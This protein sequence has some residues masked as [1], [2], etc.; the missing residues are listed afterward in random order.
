M[1][2]ER[3]IAIWYTGAH[4]VVASALLAQR[5]SARAAR[6]E[7]TSANIP[8]E[9]RKWCRFGFCFSSRCAAPSA[10]IP[11]R[12]RRHPL[13]LSLHSSLGSPKGKSLDGLFLDAPRK[14]HG[15]DPSKGPL[16]GTP[17][18]DPA[19]TWKVRSRDPEVTRTV[20]RRFRVG[21]Q[22]RFTEGSR[23]V[24]G[25]FTE[26]RRMLCFGAHPLR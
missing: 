6:V 17:R 11:R 8:L 16:E 13:L 1:Y 18:R 7:E 21:T 20:P 25:G 9:G 14:L 4:A 23:K 10:T 26:G 19:V 12:E 22:P 2:M 3:W 15:R 24:H 5:A